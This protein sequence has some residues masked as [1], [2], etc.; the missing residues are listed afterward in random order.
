[1]LSPV[2]CLPGLLQTYEN[3]K[4]IQHA[5]HLWPWGLTI[6]GCVTI[7]THIQS[8]QLRTKVPHHSNPHPDS[9]PKIGLTPQNLK[10]QAETI[11][12]FCPLG[13]TKSHDIH[14]L[15]GWCIWHAT[16][17]HPDLDPKT[18]LTSHLVKSW[19]DRKFVLWRTTC[20]LKFSVC[21]SRKNLHYSIHNPP[22]QTHPQRLGSRRKVRK[23]KVTLFLPI[24]AD[25]VQWHSFCARMTPLD[26][27]P[28]RSKCAQTKS[29]R[30]P[31]LDSHHKVRI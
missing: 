19:C 26:K 22:I 25:Q 8:W 17:P 2:V 4:K 28:H 29:Q 18:R 24:R 16:T 12:F 23:S 15:Q 6:L 30:S 31:K 11:L 13:L 20:S 5:Q 1:M 9:S 14:H 27:N 3:D 7:I 21:P 10:I